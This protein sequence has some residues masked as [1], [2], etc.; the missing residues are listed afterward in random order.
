MRLRARYGFDT[1]TFYLPLPPVQQDGT[2]PF[3]SGKRYIYEVTLDDF[4]MI[5]PNVTVRDYDTV[6]TVSELEF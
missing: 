6:P 3:K 2:H 5:S 1:E 4:V